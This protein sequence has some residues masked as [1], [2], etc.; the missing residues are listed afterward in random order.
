MKQP[1]ILRHAERQARLLESA[2]RLV[3]AGGR[4]VYSVCSGEPE[5]GEAVVGPFLKARED[6]RGAPLPA[7]SR[8]FLGEDGFLRTAPEHDGGD[9]FFLAVLDRA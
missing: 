9:A 5:E 2:S 7:W 6:F 3:R 1:E 8:P 4:L